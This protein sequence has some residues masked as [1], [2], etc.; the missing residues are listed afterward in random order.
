MSNQTT[1]DATTTARH[2]EWCD[3]R[4]CFRSHFGWLHAGAPMT[5]QIREGQITLCRFCADEPDAPEGPD[6]WPEVGIEIT[7]KDVLPG[8]GETR[9]T[10]PEA[11]GLAM[12][13]IVLLGEIPDFWAEAGI[14]ITSDDDFAIAITS[15]DH[16]GTPVVVR[17]AVTLEPLHEDGPAQLIEPGIGDIR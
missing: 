10:L 16:A 7:N 6:Y 11:R 5:W 9:L 1:P 12:R 14:E 17:E 2:P 15:D 8:P 13:L 3:P 4:H